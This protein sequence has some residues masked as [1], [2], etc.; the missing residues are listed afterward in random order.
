MTCPYCGGRPVRVLDTVH[1]ETYTR[2]RRECAAC[3]ARFWTRERIAAN[4]RAA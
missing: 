3:G 2:R 1:R 4:E